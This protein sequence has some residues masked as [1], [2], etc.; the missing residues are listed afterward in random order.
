MV[1]RQ[2]TRHES[3]SF[4]ENAV[5]FRHIL[6][7]KATLSLKT[8]MVSSLQTH[9]EIAPFTQNRRGLPPHPRYESDTFTDK[10]KRAAPDWRCPACMS[11][12]ILS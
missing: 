6:A 11:K 5:A 9:H 4:T 10:S 2:Q 8:L 1:L 7:K 12:T 3:G